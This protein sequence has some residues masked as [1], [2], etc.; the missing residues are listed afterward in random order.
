[1]AMEYRTPLTPLFV[2]VCDR[3]DACQLRLGYHEARTLNVFNTKRR[4]RVPAEGELVNI[5]LQ[6]LLADASGSYR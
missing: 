4:T 6:V 1:M 3:S 2:E 5:A